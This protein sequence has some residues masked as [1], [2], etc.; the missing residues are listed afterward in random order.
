MPRIETIGLPRQA[1]DQCS[2]SRS[3]IEG[4]YIVSRGV[5]DDV[6]VSSADI[7]LQLVMSARL[8]SVLDRGMLSTRKGIIY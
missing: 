7:V 1:L 3:D 4:E 6:R 5:V 8:I 2:F